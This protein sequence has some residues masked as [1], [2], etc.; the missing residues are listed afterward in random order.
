[1]GDKFSL[2]HVISEKMCCLVSLQWKISSTFLI[3]CW[4]GVG[5]T[6]VSGL[7]AS[8]CAFRHQALRETGTNMAVWGGVVQGGQVRQSVNLSRPPVPE[9]E[10]WAEVRGLLRLTAM[11]AKAN[12]C[13]DVRKSVCIG[14]VWCVYAYETENRCLKG[15]EKTSQSREYTANSWDA[16][17]H[18]RVT[19]GAGS[20]TGVQCV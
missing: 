17:N 3:G 16:T 6:G 13:I 10:E 5:F 19:H 11:W 14:F 15:K 12:T 1:M 7:L 4:V 8:P 9:E 2:V 18:T 20:G